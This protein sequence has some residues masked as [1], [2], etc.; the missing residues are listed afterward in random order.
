MI[1]LV[2]RAVSVY[3]ELLV[4]AGGGLLNLVSWLLKNCG[5][6]VRRFASGDSYVATVLDVH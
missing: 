6:F 1:L 5:S 4:T 3:L 2:I